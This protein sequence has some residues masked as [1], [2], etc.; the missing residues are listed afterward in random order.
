LKKLLVVVLLVTIATTAS[1]GDRGGGTNWGAVAGAGILG[2][3]IGGAT[4]PAPQQQIIVV[5]PQAAPPPPPP[6]APPNLINDKLLGLPPAVQMSTLA[7]SVGRGCV[8]VAAAPMGVFAQT[9]LASWSVR[10]ADGRAFAV[11]FS[12]DGKA[13]VGDCR[14]LQGTLTPCFKRF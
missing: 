8:G 12:Q 9:G 6:A 7:N 2:G 5:V 11:E 10:C 13:V 14:L 1:A 3:I 4:A